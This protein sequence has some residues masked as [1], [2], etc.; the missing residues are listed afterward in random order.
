M[1]KISTTAAQKMEK[2]ES[3][4]L[5]VG[6][7]LGDHFL[8]LDWK[9]DAVIATATF[10]G[11]EK[12]IREICAELDKFS[13]RSAV[14]LDA[15]TQKLRTEIDQ[16]LQSTNYSVQI[17]E[18]VTFDNS[19]MPPGEYRVVMLPREKN[20]AEVGSM[21]QIAIY[22]RRKNAQEK[23]SRSSNVGLGSSSVGFPSPPISSS[24]RPL[25]DRST[26]A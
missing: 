26:P 24:I 13:K 2:V 7:D 9:D 20:L 10:R 14:D 6:L 23:L 16:Q 22:R 18:S 17:G 8:R 21:S 11:S 12:E 19:V 5:T 15:A 3:Q 4:R 25:A 1:K